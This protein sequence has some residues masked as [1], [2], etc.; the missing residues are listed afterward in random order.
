MEKAYELLKKEHGILPEFEHIDKEFE[1]STIDDSKFLLRKIKKKMADRI[2]PVLD[3]LEQIL[4][5]DASSFTDLYEFKC[6]TDGEKKQAFELFQTLMQQYRL[7]L[8]TDILGDDEKDVQA[9][10]SFYDKWKQQKK[11]AAGFVKKIR[12]CW[13]KDIEAKEILEYL[14]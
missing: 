9:I 8:E 6:F 4:S 12:Q 1:I 2:V 13:E 14:G 3:I 5:P 10:R 7:L 11:T